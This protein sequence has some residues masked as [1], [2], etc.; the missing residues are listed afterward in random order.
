MKWNDH[1]DTEKLHIVKNTLLSLG[2][3][4]CHATTV[5]YHLHLAFVESLP[6]DPKDPFYPWNLTFFTNGWDFACFPLV[7]KTPMKLSA[8]FAE[9]VSARFCTTPWFLGFYFEVLEWETTA[10]QRDCQNAVGLASKQIL[11]PKSVWLLLQESC[12]LVQEHSP[13]W[14]KNL[15]H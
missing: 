6:K 12:S 10:C 14:L 13:I 5:S 11:T 7:W 9:T 2:K 8:T 1:P 3:I 4:C 15:S